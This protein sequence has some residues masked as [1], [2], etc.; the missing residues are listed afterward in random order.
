MK[1]PSILFSIGWRKL[2]RSG[3]RAVGQVVQAVAGGGT[4]V[5]ARSAQ[6]SSQRLP[7]CVLQRNASMALAPATDQRMPERFRR[8]PTMLLQPASTTPEPTHRPWA[9]NSG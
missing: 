4:P 5:V 3:D 7:E 1:F 8:L 6:K 2:A 9:R